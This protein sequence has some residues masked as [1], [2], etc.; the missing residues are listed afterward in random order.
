[1]TKQFFCIIILLTLGFSAH[2]QKG[3]TT[4]GIQYKPII[5]NWYIGTFEQD[6]NEGIL[7]SS[8]RQRF[9][10]NFGMVIR[11]GLSRNISLETGIGF[12]QR[13]FGLNFAVP[14]SGHS[15]TGRVGLIGYEI[16]ITGL[17][18]IQLGDNLFMNTSGGVSFNYFPSDVDQLVDIEDK[19]GEYFL[20]EGARLNRIHGAML[21]NIGFEYR[22]KKSGYY[23]LGASYNLP[24]APIYTFAMSYEYEGGDVVSIDNVRGGFLTVDFR[25][26]FHEKPKER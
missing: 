24:F 15:E 25:Y 7:E 1:M 13:N 11:Q 12:I 26:Y 23:Y 2:A 17:V 21:A 4:L 8:I 16:P 9:G 14:D 18:Y 3:V 10:H 22:T 20:Q 19:F 6:F 5:P